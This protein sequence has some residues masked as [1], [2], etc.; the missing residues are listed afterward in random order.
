[1]RITVEHGAFP[2]NEV[3]LRCAALDEE[4]LEVLALLRAREQKLGVWRGEQPDDLQ[5]LSPAEVLYA[6]TVEDKTFVYTEGALFRC[7]LGLAE[8][9]ARYE[10]AGMCRVNK[11]TVVNLHRIESLTSCAGRR[12]LAGM[13]GGERIV[14]SRHYAPLLRQRLGL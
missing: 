14:V 12:I 3:V 9:E 2:E 6:E 5:F 7:P 8:I 13:R 10:T 1:M 11:S 4:M